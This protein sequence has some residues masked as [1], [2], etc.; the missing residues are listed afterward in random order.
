MVNLVKSFPKLSTLLCVIMAL[1]GC[2]LSG[3]A[4]PAAVSGG[5]AGVNYTFTNVA[6]KTISYPVV[7]VEAALSKTLKKM[8]IKETKH[9]AEEGKVSVTAVAGNLDIYIDLEKITKTETSIKVNAKKGAF[10]K[11]KATATEII[12]QTEKNLEVKK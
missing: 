10:V 2:T 1:S 11:D 6:Y 9:E 3:L 12:V 4:V 5:A 7:D 8:D